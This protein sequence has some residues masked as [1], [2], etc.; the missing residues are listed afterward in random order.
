[1]IVQFEACSASIAAESHRTNWNPRV[2]MNEKG[3]V[4]H[5]SITFIQYSSKRHSPFCPAGSLRN[6]VIVTLSDGCTLWICNFWKQFGLRAKNKNFLKKHREY[7]RKTLEKQDPCVKKKPPN[8]PKSVR[9]L[10]TNTPGAW[11]HPSNA[12]LF[13]L[14][15]CEKFKCVWVNRK[16]SWRKSY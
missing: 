11:S 13:C 16:S 15:A 4:S 2:I 6:A 1:M 10:V 3:N 5:M 14:Y 8:L 9:T 12:N 7:G